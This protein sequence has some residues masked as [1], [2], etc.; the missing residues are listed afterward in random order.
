M[1]QSTASPSLRRRHR[2]VGYQLV[3]TKNLKD[4]V[5]E[6][7]QK[8]D[9]G[10]FEKIVDIVESPSKLK[11]W[12]IYESSEIKM[13]EE[14]LSGTGI[15][16]VQDFDPTSGRKNT[17]LLYVPSLNDIVIDE[18]ENYVK[19]SWFCGPAHQTKT[20]H[21]MATLRKTRKKR[22]ETR[23]RLPFICPA[24]TQIAPVKVKRV[25]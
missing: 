20:T 12:L 16:F 7:R 15:S 13:M 24:Q 8:S 14:L 18:M 9:D 19:T 2:L 25:D 5:I 4:A 21:K 23:N 22:M 6:T 3:L 10:R 17:L 1:R 11:R